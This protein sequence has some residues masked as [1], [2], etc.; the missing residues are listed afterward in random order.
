MASL[1]LRGAE[2]L[3]FLVGQVV[4][5]GLEGG[6]VRLVA[7]SY[8]HLVETRMVIFHGENHELSRGGKPR[9]RVRRLKEITQWF[10]R[11]I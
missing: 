3:L 7:V 8:T 9:H 10:A 5:Q 11:H 1:F 4:L 2:A 6:P